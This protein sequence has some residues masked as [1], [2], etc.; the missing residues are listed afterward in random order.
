MFQHP[1]THASNGLVA[2]ADKTTNVMLNCKNGEEA[3][4]VKIG[5]KWIE[6]E[7]TGKLL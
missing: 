1:S 6:R 5:E 7:S 4:R 2:S 3:E